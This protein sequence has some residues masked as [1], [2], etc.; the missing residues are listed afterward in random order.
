MKSSLR[1]KQALQSLSWPGWA[2]LGCLALAVAALLLT[3]RWEAQTSQLQAQAD[4]L[5]SQ[6]RKARAEG[7]TAA[8][9]PATP[10]QWLQA[11][12]PAALRQQRLA[13]LLEIG[14]R[15][16]L[17]SARTEHRLSVD[18]AAGL[19]RLRVNMPLTG[20]Y[21]QLRHFIEAALRQDPA[22]SLDSLKLRR[23]TPLAAEV[24]AELVWSLHGRAD[25]TELK[26]SG[27]PP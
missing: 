16:G 7:A 23:A 14:L 17:V 22:L 21:A 4:G 6:L 3:Q 5:R 24:E 18:S 25:Q 27:A 8:T 9:A 11:L 12:P 10:S 19:E 1:I 26:L 13:D 15:Q 20:G 2:G